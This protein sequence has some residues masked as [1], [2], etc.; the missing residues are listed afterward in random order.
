MRGLLLVVQQ[1]VDYDLART[2]HGYSRD[3]HDQVLE[4][5]LGLKAAANLPVL[6]RV[7][8]AELKVT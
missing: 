8:Q 7:R 6:R 3:V 1:Q 5:R 4:S 2:I